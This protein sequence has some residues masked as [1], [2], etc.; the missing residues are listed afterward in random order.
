MY[1]IGS[2]LHHF[3]YTSFG[4]K[5]T[6][7]YL[8]STRAF[9]IRSLSSFWCRPAFR[10]RSWQ[11]G[12]VPDIGEAVGPLDSNNI[13]AAENRGFIN[14]ISEMFDFSASVKQSS[15]LLVYKRHN[16]DQWNVVSNTLCIT[17]YQTRCCCIFR[18]NIPYT[19]AVH[20][21]GILSS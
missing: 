10:K 16:N 2:S 8:C 14:V 19:E 20:F 12:L 18:Q 1:I 7:Y 5:S 21:I 11:G 3:N 13:I 6:P 4:T 17:F 15:G 9:T